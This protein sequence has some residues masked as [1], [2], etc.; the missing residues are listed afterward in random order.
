[1]AQCTSFEDAADFSGSPHFDTAYG[2]ARGSGYYSSAYHAYQQH[3]Q[4]RINAHHQKVMDDILNGVFE[5][6]EA[7]L[8]GQKVN[9]SDKATINSI[10]R[11]A[12]REAERAAQAQKDQLVDKLLR[13]LDKLS[14]STVQDVSAALR[15]TSRF[16]SRVASVQSRL[17]PWLA[18]YFGVEGRT[19][20][21][22]DLLSSLERGKAKQV[23][24]ENDFMAFINRTIMNDA[25][26]QRIQKKSGLDMQELLVR[27]GNYALGEHMAER[28]RE[29]LRRM[30][31]EWQPLQDE[32]V[33][34]GGF[35][36]DGLRDAAKEAKYSELSDDIL[37]LSNKINSAQPPDG[38]LKTGGWT[39]G[40]AKKVMQN[41][42][43]EDGISHEEYQYLT[44]KIRDYNA[45]ILDKRIQSG[46]VSAEQRQAFPGFQKYVPVKSIHDNVT[47]ALND[48]DI[49]MPSSKYAFKGT[50]MEIESAW[51]TLHSYAMRTAKDIA[52]RD[53][54]LALYALLE[55]AA[56]RNGAVRTKG[57][58]LKIYE[59]PQY[60]LQGYRYN[61][62]L[63]LYYNGTREDA[64]VVKRILTTKYGGGGLVAE[65][66]VVENGKVVGTERV[67][68]NFQIPDEHYSNASNDFGGF[69]AV[70]LNEAL[71]AHVASDNKI[72]N[73]MRKATSMYGQT[74]TR[75]QPTS[76]APANVIRDVME[77]LVNLPSREYMSDTGQKVSGMTVLGSY[78][79][80]IPKAGRTLVQALMGKVDTESKMGQRWQEFHNNGLHMQRTPG[81][82]EMASGLRNL[83]MNKNAVSS[84]EKTQLQK[85]LGGMGVVGQ[86]AMS[87]LDA[88]NDWFNTLGSFSHYN[89]LRDSGLSIHDATVGTLEM[90]NLYNTG[91][92]TPVMQMFFPFVKPTVMSGVA[93]S[94]SLGLAPNAQ[95]KF[96]PNIKG[97]ATVA[98]MTAGMSML[99]PLL[100]E[101]MGYDENGNSKY[102][103][104]SLNQLQSFIPIGIGDEDYAKIAT[105]FGMAQMA[106]TMAVGMDR[107]DRGLMTPE[108]VAFETMFA[109]LKNVSPGNFP[110]FNMSTDPFDY[111]MHL[112]MPSITTPFVELATD[113]NY[114]GARIS[115]ADERGWNLK[116][117]SGLATTERNYH[118]FAKLMQETTGVDLAPE[119]YKSLVNSFFLGPLRLLSNAIETNGIYEATGGLIGTEMGDVKQRS[120]YPTARE[121]LGSWL[122]A[123]GMT[124]W[125]GKTGDTSQTMYYNALNE[126]ERRAKA[127][128][129][130]MRAH[131]ERDVQK[132]D[133]ARAEQMRAAGW[134]EYDIED[135]LALF[136]MDSARRNMAKKFKP[137]AEQAVMAGDAEEVK[138]VYDEF[139]RMR[140]DETAQL[141]KKLHFYGAY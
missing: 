70:E 136:H 14:G 97:I 76:F 71:T 65:V 128:G 93:L 6:E 52:F 59:D 53:P 82:D 15:K 79:Y 19:V 69:S 50:K 131:G 63:E 51:H 130:D 110:Q 99:I 41:L 123:L 109:A 18:K 100:R 16:A 45:Y 105:P 25:E 138:R 30:I 64:E 29:V 108:D 20:L 13:Y 44:Q 66:P 107:L 7:P 36:K 23:G 81:M 43:D 113:R 117:D 135:A 8:G 26:V 62:L 48:A 37:N 17:V 139:G 40:W 24:V 33:L 73:G 95:G 120:P 87:V 49:Y 3:V 88:W 9:Q 67:L 11:E 57:N 94:R 114:L 83:K 31:A 84:K 119:Q 1:M 89:A 86:K 21:S 102:D 80:N 27:A 32:Y 55:N 111:F 104:L 58:K 118:A 137:I 125:Y 98:G 28:N 140:S 56:G 106:I 72:V 35:F 10:S 133:E 101:S 38:S 96:R 91:T 75:L 46:L 129:I 4:D 74:M 115:Y 122:T 77:K 92:A 78:I 134:S 2:Y 116:A 90:M 126:F 34:R 22:H 121:E 60:G 39:N 5:G 112:L 12:A 61:H 127:A 124:R 85:M 42:V 47:G 54:S 132:A 141:V 103:A 68:V